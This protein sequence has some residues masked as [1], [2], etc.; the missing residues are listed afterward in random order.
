MKYVITL[1]RQFGSL[2]RSIARQLSEQLQ[3][4]YYDRDIVEQASQELGV[5]VETIDRVEGRMGDS[6]FWKRAFPLGSDVAMQD[7]LF[8]VQSR[9]ITQLADRQ[10][11]IIVGRCAD[12]V[13]RNEP[14]RLSVFVFAPDEAR[15]QNCTQRLNMD[16]AEARRMMKSVDAARKSYHRKY[17]GYDPGDLSHYDLLINSAVLGTAGTAKYLAA[18]V[19]ERFGV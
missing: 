12:Y 18:M 6:T 16:L 1:G 7:Q 2:G 10:S 11:C 17:T 4:E 15:L 9:I 19:R 14:N 13:L 3:I 5:T 8:A